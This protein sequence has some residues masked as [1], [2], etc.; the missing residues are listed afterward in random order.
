[1]IDVV[2]QDKLNSVYINYTINYFRGLM[3]LSIEEILLGVFVV[4]F[5]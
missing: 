3:R 1:M 5:Y 4:A 2:K